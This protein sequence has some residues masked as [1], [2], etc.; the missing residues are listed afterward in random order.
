VGVLGRFPELVSPL[1]PLSSAWSLMRFD[2][3]ALRDIFTEYRR[4]DYLRYRDMDYSAPEVHAYS[5][6]VQVPAGRSHLQARYAAQAATHRGTVPLVTKQ[7]AYVLAPAREWSGFGSLGVDVLLPE[8]WKAATSP[9]LE[10]HGDTLQGEYSEVPADCIAV[11]LQPPMRL[12]GAIAAAGARL[13]Y[14]LALFGGPIAMI[15]GGRKKRVAGSPR[16]SA[17]GMGVMWG[18]ALLVT[19]IA[20]LTVPTAVAPSEW[21]FPNPFEFI[22]GVPAALVVAA[23]AVPIGI[24]LY[25]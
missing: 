1:F 3:G 24:V 14:L 2:A 15:Y 13:L 22:L 25:D 5:F 10:R 6:D 11:S 23:I 8:N 18:A 7:F 16:R 19:G 20:A 12:P 9:R 4:L 17:T 21:T